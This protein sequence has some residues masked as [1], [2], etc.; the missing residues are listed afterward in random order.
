MSITSVI[1]TSDLPMIIQYEV[2]QAD[3]D[4]ANRL[5]NSEPSRSKK[6]GDMVHICPHAQALKK[7]PGVLRAMCSEMFMFFPNW[8]RDA[9][10]QEHHTVDVYRV[11]DREAQKAIALW[12]QYSTTEMKP[13]SNIITYINTMKRGEL[14]ELSKQYQEESSKLTAELTQGYTHFMNR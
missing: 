11:T 1:K 7:L 8:E 9:E 2:T 12:P 6:M 4:E 14:K 5:W 10:K 3:I 13:H